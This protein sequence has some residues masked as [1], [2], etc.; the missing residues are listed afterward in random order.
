MPLNVHALRDGSVM[1]F[2]TFRL[3]LLI[4][5]NK[6]TARPA[7]PCDD[8]RPTAHNATFLRHYRLQPL[9]ERFYTLAAVY[10]VL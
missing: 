2:E 6:P 4:G 10:T 7:R 3:T 8:S 9:N 5:A 1:V